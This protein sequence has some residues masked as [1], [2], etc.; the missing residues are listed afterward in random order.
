M[1]YV[2]TAHNS[3]TLNG[4]D[5]NSRETTL[6]V[7]P[8][9][10]A[11]DPGSYAAVALQNNPVA[12]WMLNETND[13]V[14]GTVKGYDYTG[15]G[16][17][18]TFGTAIQDG[19]TGIQGPRPPSYP[20]FYADQNAILTVNGNL[21]SMAYVP[22]LN[23]TNVETTVAMWIKPN[24][25]ETG[26]YAH[27]LIGGRNNTVAGQVWQL[28]YSAG[29]GALGYNWNDNSATYTYNTGLSPVQAVWN[30]V[31]M[32]ITKTNSQFYLYTL[33]SAG[34]AILQKNVQVVANT[35]PI[36]MVAEQRSSATI[37]TP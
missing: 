21:N 33:N 6:Y 27:G 34:Q 1:L 23:D 2:L 25:G 35:T 13:P 28:G 16:H 32:V 19:F 11:P 18:V 4:G 24:S 20:G 30:F 7:Q 5:Q 22:P 12:L 9:P 3:G 31:S 15:N 14:S 36:T 37:L 29:T 26:N 10:P 8:I 17:N